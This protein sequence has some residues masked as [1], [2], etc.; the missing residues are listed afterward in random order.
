MF[1]LKIAYQAENQ[2]TGEMEK[3]RQLLSTVAISDGFM[4]G[5]RQSIAQR[6]DSGDTAV[7]LI[8]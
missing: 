4:Q 2:E 5:I 1:R 3:A 7:F 6:I 8:R